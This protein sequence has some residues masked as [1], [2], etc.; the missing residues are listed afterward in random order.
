MTGALAP[1]CNSVCVVAARAAAKALA[2]AARGHGS[3]VKLPF[4]TEVNRNMVLQ[5]ERGGLERPPSV[6]RLRLLRP[7]RRLAW[8]EGERP[9]ATCQTAVRRDSGTEKGFGLRAAAPDLDRKGT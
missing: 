4:A 1:A 9:R 5:N 2:V 6:R 8:D 3:H 7:W